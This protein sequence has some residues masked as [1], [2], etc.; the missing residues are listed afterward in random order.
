MARGSQ[1]LGGVVGLQNMGNTCFMN[2]VLQI[3]ARV[4]PLV[5]MLRLH[6]AR[7]I[8]ICFERFHGAAGIIGPI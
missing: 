4:E 2:A 6:D 5:D 1:L 3:F 7:S 8:E